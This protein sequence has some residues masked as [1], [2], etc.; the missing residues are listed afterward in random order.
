MMKSGAEGGTNDEPHAY[1]QTFRIQYPVFVAA[2]QNQC[3]KHTHTRPTKKSVRD[4]T[5]KGNVSVLHV[6][7]VTAQN[8]QAAPK[9]NRVGARVGLTAARIAG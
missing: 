3:R 8:A 6:T 2:L 7:L 4:V 5:L 1:L 9:R